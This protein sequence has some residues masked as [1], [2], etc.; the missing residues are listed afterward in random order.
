MNN[1]QKKLLQA[2]RRDAFLSMTQI[3]RE[4]GINDQTLRANLKSLQEKD[5]IKKATVLLDTLR[6][7]YSHH[8][9]FYFDF[10]DGKDV[11][12]LTEKE[13]LNM[14]LQL[15]IPNIFLAE[16]FFE[17]GVQLDRFLNEIEGKTKPRKILFWQVKNE[18]MREN[19][20][21]EEIRDS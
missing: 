2:L 12:L 1:S 8:I 13:N 17:N 15:D 20:L 21:C 7:G 19:F 14:L 3:H 10:Y 4:T 16:A 5:I 11:E 18:L 6:L 9:I